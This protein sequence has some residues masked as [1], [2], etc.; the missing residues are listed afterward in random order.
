MGFGSGSCC[1]PHPSEVGFRP[2][3][4]PVLEGQRR[5]LEL[6]AGG[7][8]RPQILRVETHEGLGPCAFLPS[9]R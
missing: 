7:I 8:F 6:S 5:T 2:K 1:L 3:N 4:K 9:L